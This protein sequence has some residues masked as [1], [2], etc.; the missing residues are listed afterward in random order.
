MNDHMIDIHSGIYEDTLRNWYIFV[1][2]GET[3]VIYAKEF[4]LPMSPLI[5]NRN[6]NMISPDNH[7]GSISENQLKMLQA[8]KPDLR[9]EDIING[10]VEDIPIHK[11]E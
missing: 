5:H 3:S 2:R 11:Y 10:Y 1:F 6:Q 8:L 9:I 4:Y 7:I